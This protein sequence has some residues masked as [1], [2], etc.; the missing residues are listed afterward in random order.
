MA[1]LAILESKKAFFSTKMNLPQIGDEFK[2]QSHEI[3][4]LFF[5][6]AITPRPLIKSLKKFKILFRIHGAV[7]FKVSRISTPESKFVS[8]DSQK[9]LRSFY[10][11]NV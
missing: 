8:L 2:R 11:Y 6:K 5:H 7:D 1:F 9:I 4:N 3:F 10:L